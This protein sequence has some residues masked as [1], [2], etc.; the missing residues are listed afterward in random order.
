M[1][2]SIPAEHIAPVTE[3]L[4]ALIKAAASLPISDDKPESGTETPET[5]YLKQFGARK[6]SLEKAHAAALDIRKF[7]IDLYWKRSAYFWALIAA[8]IAAYGLLLSSAMKDGKTLLFTTQYLLFGLSILGC[9]FSRAWLL[10]NQGSKF[11][12]ANWEAQV[13]ILEEA[14]MGPLY[15]SVLAD[16]RE[17]VAQKLADAENQTL[18]PIDGCHLTKLGA[19]IT[20][21]RNR[22]KAKTK[23]KKEW[24]FEKNQVFAPIYSPTKINDVMAKLFYALFALL[25]C[26]SGIILLAR[27]AH[28]YLP[29]EWWL[30][31][32]GDT[33]ETAAKVT[34]FAIALIAFFRYERL[35]DSCRT[36]TPMDHDLNLTQRKASVKEDLTERLKA[37]EQ[38]KANPLATAEDKKTKGTN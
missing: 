29:T 26:V 28:P 37:Y 18:T 34:L 10:V 36:T 27:T 38:W 1:P 35:L 31:L 5:K 15:K 20:H 13:E 2:P 25:G 8:T 17:N 16:H 14:V 3:A 32:T 6:D 24:Y 30:S 4:A 7:E 9:L 19:H 21:F 12:Q 33:A 23:Q 11:W 22:R